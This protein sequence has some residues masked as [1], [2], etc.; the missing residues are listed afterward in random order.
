[1]NGA[2]RERVGEG[3]VIHRY[4]MT[5]S[6]PRVWKYRPIQLP[7]RRDRGD[8]RSIH[9]RLILFTSEDSLIVYFYIR[10]FEAYLVPTAVMTLKLLFSDIKFAS[11]ILGFRSGA[12]VDSVG[13]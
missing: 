4:S 10:D 5:G 3:R 11:E 8:T 2:S 1:M 6:S 13:G 12:V 9:R 7:I